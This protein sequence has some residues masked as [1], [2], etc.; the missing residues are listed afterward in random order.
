[1]FKLKKIIM[2]FILTIAYAFSTT[3]LSASVVED[4]LLPE[5]NGWTNGTLR[6]TRLDTVS[7][8]RGIWLERDY[9]TPEG[10][11]FHAIRIDGDGVKSWNLNKDALTADDGPIGS[12]ATY[13]TI[14]IYTQVSTAESNFDDPN[15]P[16]YAAIE[17]HPL[18]GLSLIVQLNKKSAL[19]L[20]SKNANEQEVIDAVIA[21]IQNLY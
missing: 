3:I 19:T 13:K 11:F 10:K 20:E 8:N 12:R 16:Y 5:I 17:Q 2:F 6:I 4:K 7:G 21:I 18:T 14:K 15:S 9:K 1:M